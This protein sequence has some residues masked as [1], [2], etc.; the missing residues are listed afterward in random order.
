[1]SLWHSTF[2]DVTMMLVLSQRSQ[3]FVLREQKYFPIDLIDSVFRYVLRQ[4]VWKYQVHRDLHIYC[5]PWEG[6]TL[7]F[8]VPRLPFVSSLYCLFFSTSIYYTFDLTISFKPVNKISWTSTSRPRRRSSPSWICRTL[9]HG[10]RLSTAKA[11][12]RS[13]RSS[14]KR[15]KKRWA[16]E[17]PLTH[18][19]L[20][21]TNVHQGFTE[22]S[23]LVVN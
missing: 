5:L 6:D 4:T 7:S 21:F 10:K 2:Y 12:S 13:C 14:W 1:M 8:G 20:S 16:L 11:R 19:W 23:L 3:S 18:T 17:P 22:T 15:T 9:K